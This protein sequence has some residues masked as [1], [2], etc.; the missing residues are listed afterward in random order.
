MTAIFVILLILCSVIHSYSNHYPVYDRIYD[1]Y[2][3]KEQSS[4][5]YDTSRV[6][7]IKIYN[8]RI[9]A[10]L[11]NAYD[12]VSTPDNEI[13]SIGL[14]R[15]IDDILACFY[16]KGYSYL[17]SKNIN[18]TTFIRGNI[19]RTFI[20][21]YDKYIFDHALAILYAYKNQTGE[22]FLVNLDELEKQWFE[23]AK[24]EE[25]F[26]KLFTLHPDTKDVMIFNG[27]LYTIERRSSCKNI[28]VKMNL[29]SHTRSIVDDTRLYKF[30]FIPFYQQH[31]LYNTILNN[32][33]LIGPDV[34]FNPRGLLPI[35]VLDTAIAMIVFILFR[36]LYN[37][38]R[39]LRNRIPDEIKNIELDPLCINKPVNL[40]RC[41]VV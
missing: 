32:T 19:M 10:S 23:S 24:T 12:F 28:V 26:H 31:R 2:P 22:L 9:Y 38:Y 18:I 25:F 16:F 41:I 36:I 8:N 33:S 29:T 1:V 14:I 6:C 34:N 39:N 15:A 30:D 5:G 27:S 21:D 40:G 3:K 13:R 17:I 20:F 37:R 4:Y 11:A 7:E 35:H